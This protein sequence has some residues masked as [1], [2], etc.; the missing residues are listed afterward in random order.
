MILKVIRF[1]LSKIILALDALFSPKSLVRTPTKQA[2][3]DAATRQL[4]LYQ[5][6]GCPFCVKVRRQIKRLGLKMEFRD[7]QTDPHWRQELITQGGELQVP[8]L[9]I[10]ENGSVQWMYESSEINAY[11]AKRFG[12]A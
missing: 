12:A 9:R 6:V 7:A 5:F 3:V 2:E 8:C 4:S 11:L 1:I 10:E